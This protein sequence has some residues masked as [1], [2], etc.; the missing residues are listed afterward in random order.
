[1]I[2]FEKKK[3]IIKKIARINT[4]LNTKTMLD[5]LKAFLFHG[6]KLWIKSD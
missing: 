3:I 2:L 4:S 1:M 6:A 5:V